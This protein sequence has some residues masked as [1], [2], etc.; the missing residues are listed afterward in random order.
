MQPPRWEVLVVVEVDVTGKKN[1]LFRLLGRVCGKSMFILRT[2]EC[3]RLGSGMCHESVS[4]ISHRLCSFVSLSA[5]LVKD[6][7][8]E[9]QVQR[10]LPGIFPARGLPTPPNKIE[11][12]L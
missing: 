11:R 4:T 7:C 6:T 10:R 3:I 12:D 1:S 5:E 2:G 9:A 8:E